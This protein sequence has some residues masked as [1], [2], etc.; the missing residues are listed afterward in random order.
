MDRIT[1][2]PEELLVRILCSLSIKEAARS[3]V[4]SGVWRGLWKFVTCSLNFEASQTLQPNPEEKERDDCVERVTHVL[5]SHEAP[6]IVELRVSLDLTQQ[7][8]HNIDRW[9]EIALMKGFKADISIRGC[10]KLR[11]LRCLTCKVRDLLLQSKGG[12]INLLFLVDSAPLLHKFRV[13]LEQGYAIRLMKGSEAVGR[14]IGKV[15]T[16]INDDGKG[17]EML[18]LKEVEIVGFVGAKADIALIV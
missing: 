2:L 5:N 11:S 12:L 13:E 6:T 1:E 10:P 15:K 3:G 16:M 4:V 18:N 14:V 9:I 8:S 7:Y 17:P